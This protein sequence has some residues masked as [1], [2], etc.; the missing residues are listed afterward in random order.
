MKRSSKAVGKSAERRETRAAKQIHPIVIY[1]F[2]NPVDTRHLRKLYEAIAEWI[3]QDQR[4]CRPITIMN[5][6]TYHHAKT[7]Q[8]MDIDK[9]LSDSVKAI[10][11][12]I[13]TWAVDTCQM[14]LAGFG[15]CYDLA[16]VNDVFWLIPGDFHY[17]TG[18][19]NEALKKMP[20]IA[21]NVFDGVCELCL[22]EIKV[23]LNSAKNLIDTYGTY[24][25][26]YNWFPGEAQG[27]RK[28]TDRP[29]TEFLAIGHDYLKAA[30]MRPERWYAYE[31]TIVILL[32]GMKGIKQM[33]RILPVRLGEVID[34][35]SGRS[36][37]SGAMQQIERTERVLKLYWRELNETEDPNWPDTFRKLDAQSEQIRGAA[38]IIMQQI[39]GLH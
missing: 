8:Q 39:L 34:D 22:G 21:N 7:E 28:I 23:P 17:D 3:K 4:Y 31:Q 9:F 12:V 2:V 25:L 30:L 36:S 14:W 15:H 24:G 19:G 27:I 11:D 20:S 38:M 32:Q 18:P 1:P 35:P 37:L 10:S 6:Q 16:G 33:R 29:R 26:L 5:Q 13:P